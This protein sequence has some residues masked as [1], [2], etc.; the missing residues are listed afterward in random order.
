[1][2][3][4]VWIVVVVAIVV[5]A[6]LYVMYSG[7][8]N[9]SALKPHGGLVEWMAGTT[10]DN[11]V[12]Y[13]AKGI[14]VPPLGSSAQ[15]TEGFLHFQEMCVVCHGAPGELPGEIGVG[16]YPKPPDL[17]EAI[18]DWTPAQIYWILANG[19]KDTGM[20]AFSPTHNDEA[21]WAMTSFAMLLPNMSPA[22]Y[23]SIKTAN[24]IHSEQE[25]K[26]EPETHPEG[27]Y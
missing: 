13:H 6:G 27:N 22:Q 4:V 8:Y 24:H 3:V 10:S 1:M 5:L 12:R 21:L 2:R 19:F 20:P 11:S 16:L 23:D 14:A 15:I 25:E 7:V 18:S 9:I 26:G 17:H